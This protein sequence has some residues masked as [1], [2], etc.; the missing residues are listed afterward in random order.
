MGIDQRIADLLGRMTLAETAGMLFQTMIAVGSGD[1][2]EPNSAFRTNSAEHMIK[3]QRLTHFNVIRATDDAR[4]LAE[5]QN[6]VQ[7]LAA[8]TGS[9]IPVT[10]STD[11]R[12]HFTENVG[13]AA[14]A[15][16]FS[17]WP[18]TLGMAAIGSAELVQRF[19]YI[20]R[21]EHWR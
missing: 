17:Q 11:P 19:A 7:K 2:S 4:T 20:A 8:S 13:T 3:E 10:L 18:E 5:W 12:H 16:A 21:Q 15:R 14:A 6:R 1:L 9:G